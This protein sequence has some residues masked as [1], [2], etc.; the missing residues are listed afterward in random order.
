MKLYQLIIVI[1]L[2][3]SSVAHSQSDLPLRLDDSKI[4]P[5]NNLSNP[6]LQ[7]SLEQELNYELQ[8]K[9]KVSDMKL[10]A[11]LSLLNLAGNASV[12]VKLHV[13]G[14]MDNPKITPIINKTTG[15]IKRLSCLDATSVSYCT[16]VPPPTKISLSTL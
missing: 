11:E 7:K 4:K 12:D 3:I 13:T 5:L 10:P 9:V 14:T 1:V 16:A 8:T 15:I 2:F 6:L